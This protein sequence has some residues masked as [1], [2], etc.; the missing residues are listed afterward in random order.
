VEGLKAYAAE[1]R[2]GAFPD[3]EHAYSMKA[4]EIEKLQVAVRK[5]PK[6]T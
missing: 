2:A 4:E 6:R 5:L 1:V 3:A